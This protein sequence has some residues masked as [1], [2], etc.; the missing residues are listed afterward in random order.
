MAL[1][2]QPYLPLFVQDYLTDEK[3][4]ECS[5]QSQGVYIKIMC[6]MHKSET[7]GKILLKQ[8]DKQKGK[9]INNF[10]CKFV[11]HLPFTEQIILDSLTELLE[12][13]VLFI[14]NDFLCQK[15]MIKDNDISIARGKAGK[16]G[17]ETTQKKNKFAK[18]KSK[19]NSEYEYENENENENE[20]IN[21]DKDKSFNLS[22]VKKDFT[23][24]TN[25]FIDHRI[26]MGQE[27]KTT[28]EIKTFY[29]KLMRLSDSKKDTANKLVENAIE[30]GWRSVFELR[31]NT[32]KKQGRIQHDTDY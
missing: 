25:E 17:G 20:N 2:N 18:A 14:E 7:Y 27:F 24:I 26:K 16:S 6:L 29:D 28:Y 30:N 1:R 11:K 10:A 21:E 22:F 4:N 19:A 12:E 13:K 31:E 9:Q 3:L 15:R 5:A 32:Q 23:K 8:K